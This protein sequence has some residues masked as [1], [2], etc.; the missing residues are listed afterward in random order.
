M[1]LV[2]K[3]TIWFVAGLAALVVG[4]TVALQAIIAPGFERAEADRAE[5]QTLSAVR[6]LDS[7]LESLRRLTIGMSTTGPDTPVMQSPRDWVETPA[8]SLMRKD[9]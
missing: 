9:R 1:N 7:K 8:S 4:V 5:R 2:V 6:V 3:T